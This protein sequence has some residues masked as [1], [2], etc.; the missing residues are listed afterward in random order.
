[1]KVVGV[2]AEYN[3]F[4][5]GH[6][7][8]LEELRKRT[9]ADY[10][11]VAMSGDFLQRGVPAIIDKYTRAK[12]ALLEGA[13]LVLEIP[14]LWSTASAEYF[15]SSGVN[16][17]CETGVVDCIGYGVEQNQPKLLA[18]L[19][20]LLTETPEALD[21]EIVFH[22]KN[23]L[24]YPVAR[25]TAITSLFSEYNAAQAEELLQMPNNILAIEYEKALAKWNRLTGRNVTGIPIER[26]GDGYHDSEIRSEYASATAIRKLLED[27]SE[28]SHAQLDAVMPQQNSQMLL[29]AHLKRQTLCANDFSQVLYASLLANQKEGYE[30]FA[31]CSSDLSRKIQN[32]LSEFISFTQFCSLLKSKDLTYTRISRVLLH[33]MLGI[34]KE[35]Y[36]IGSS[37][38]FNAYLRVLGFKSEASPLLSEIK[39]NSAIPLLTKVADAKQ[40]VP[41]DA[42][43]LFEAD[44]AAADL[45]R[46]IAMIKSGQRLSN[47]F[48]TEI[49]KL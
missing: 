30:R 40:I 21:E 32:H 44:L 47:E 6:K 39:K 33:I 14:A 13:D 37:H 2:I 3:P 34:T 36:E 42:F 45:Y 48:N 8:Q 31:D 43:P 5:N 46:G 23:G 35:Q 9:Q 41:T 16:L 20:K 4:H 25:A 12:M 1:M 7:Y 22:Q 24:S 49:I 38:S 29:D 15:A 11:I 28:V 19:V 27:N 10:I 17:L 26:I 18:A